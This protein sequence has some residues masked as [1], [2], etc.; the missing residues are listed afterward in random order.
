MPCFPAGLILHEDEGIPKVLLEVYW[1]TEILESLWAV[2]AF[3]VIWD[4]DL[5]P[6]VVQYEEIL[7]KIV[8]HIHLV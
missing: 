6:E 1:S 3:K 8:C 5:S 7:S 4:P 2:T